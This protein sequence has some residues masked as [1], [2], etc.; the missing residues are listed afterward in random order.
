M[1]RH[2]WAGPSRP[3]APSS[4]SRSRA[5]AAALLAGFALLAAACS[6]SAS[7]GG[8]PAAGTASASAEPSSA[9]ASGTAAAASGTSALAAAQAAVS[10]YEKQPATL[11]GITPLTSKPPTGKTV[12]F[13]DGGVP[14]TKLAASGTAAAA[15]ALGWTFKDIVVDAANVSNVA[16]GFQQ[17]L[18]FKPYMVVTDGLPITEW[19]SVLPAYKKAGV[20]IIPAYDVGDAGSTV[21]PTMNVGGGYYY[22]EAAVMLA[23]WFIASSG[24][25]GHALLVGVAGFDQATLFD[26]SFLATV[27]KDC[28]ACQISQVQLTAA[29]AV[30]NQGGPTI[31]N[32]LRRDP[33]LKYMIISNAPFLAGIHSSLAAAGLTGIQWAGGSGTITDLDAI[34]SNQEAA[35]TGVALRIAGWEVVDAGL[36]YYE[37]M[38]YA[39]DYGQLPTQ[40]QTADNRSEWQ[41]TNSFQ[42]PANYASLFEQA[43]GV[44]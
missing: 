3:H 43:W 27:A 21:V 40:L 11:A 23:E 1:I 7:S 14:Q 16:Q 44:K 38:P 19:Q 31:I 42:E 35:T 41:L 12:V 17:A 13:I 30:N 5:S 4:R 9:T 36:R 6:S 25:Q 26:N 18:V 15:A 28:P 22:S 20:P 2:P 33:S 32:A 34:V 37:H 39:S 10:H 8:G 29:Q 24:A